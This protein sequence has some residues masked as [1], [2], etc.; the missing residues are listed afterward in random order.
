MQ[1]LTPSG[2]PD[3]GELIGSGEGL[4]SCQGFFSFLALLGRSEPW[5]PVATVLPLAGP[6]IKF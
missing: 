4:R 5:G 2:L 3:A 1:I 6:V